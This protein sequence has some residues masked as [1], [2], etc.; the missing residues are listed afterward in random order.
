MLGGD[1][2]GLTYDHRLG[3]VGEAASGPDALPTGV[4]QQQL[5]GK[6]GERVARDDRRTNAVLR[7]H[8][9]FVTSLHVAIDDVVV[10]E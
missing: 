3:R 4:F 2:F 7:P 6:R 8:R 10:D 1:V 5:E 9:R